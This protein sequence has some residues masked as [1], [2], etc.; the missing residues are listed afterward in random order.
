MD[1][2][3]AEPGD[4]ML[5]AY[6]SERDAACP[7]CGYNLRGLTGRACPECNQRLRLLVG[8]EEP[9]LGLWIAGLLG[10]AAGAGFNGL[11]VGYAVIQISVR[12]FRRGFFDEFTIY[13]GAG[14]MVMGGLVFLW[15]RFGRRIRRMGLFAKLLLVGLSWFLSAV[16]LV[17]F[18]YLVR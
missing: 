10:A 18:S 12:G 9:K 3:L 8:L 15:I 14:L 1:Q 5:T 2:L 6:L 4:D 7:G 11:L 13:N 16:D 17:W